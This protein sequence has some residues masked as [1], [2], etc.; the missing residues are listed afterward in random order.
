MIHNESGE[1]LATFDGPDSYAE[2]KAQEPSKTTEGL[3]DAQ[4]RAMHAY[5]KEGK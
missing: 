1:V 2:A 3:T 4:L 5:Y